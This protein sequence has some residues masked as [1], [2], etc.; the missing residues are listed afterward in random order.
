M[1]DQLLFLGSK[2]N[3]DC[4]IVYVDYCPDKRW[5]RG[6]NGWVRESWC[7]K[8]PD[9]TTRAPWLDDHFFH[10]WES[11]GPEAARDKSRYDLSYNDQ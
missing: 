6:N 7:G 2:P 9:G 1:D 11:E 4:M 5:F 10:L 8:F 3:H